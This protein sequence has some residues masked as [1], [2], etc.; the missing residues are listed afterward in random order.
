MPD[1]AQ[2]PR[3]VKTGNDRR[4]LPCPVYP[5]KQ[6]SRH[7]RKGLSYGPF[8]VIR[9]NGVR[10]GG[11]LKVRAAEPALISGLLDQLIDSDKEVWWQGD[12][13]RLGCPGVDRKLEPS[14]LH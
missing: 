7:S 11:W 5:P 14:W 4:R 8:A 13:E 2:C 9:G 1:Q 10:E 6:T 3:W 12:T